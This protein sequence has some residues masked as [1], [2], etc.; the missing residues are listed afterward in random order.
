MAARHVN[1]AIPGKEYDIVIAPG[2]LS[3]AG[4]ILRPRI[5]SDKAALVF[6]EYV[7]AHYRANVLAGLS[8]CFE[9]VIENTIPSGEEHKNLGT[10]E[11]LYDHI[12]RH[13]IDRKTPVI[14]VGGG[15][16]GDVA[17][18]V[19]ATILRGVP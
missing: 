4:K 8:E 15:V 5:D 17:G 13:K 14:A 9:R 1:V 3:Q 16:V 11:R 2:L 19:A 12:L 6:D 10:V 7:A 18:F